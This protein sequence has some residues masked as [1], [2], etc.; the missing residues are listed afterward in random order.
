MAFRL[1]KQFMETKYGLSE[2]QRRIIATTDKAKGTLKTLADRK[3]YTT[4]TI[5]DDIGGRYSV[6]TSVGL[7]P[8]AVAGID[9]DAMMQ[10][11]QEASKAY[12]SPSIEKN[13][14]YAYAVS[15]R[16]LES[17]GKG[18]EL[19]VSYESQMAMFAE[20]WKQLF[21][22]SEGK[23]N[24]GLY[25]ASVNFSTDLH[26]MGQFV[27]EGTKS[28]FETLLHVDKPTLNAAFPSDGEDLDG[29]NYLAGK[30]LD[31]VNKNAALGTLQAHHDEGGIPVV[32]IHF[33]TM[34]AKNFGYLAQFFFIACGMSVYLLGV[35]PFNQPG[36]EVYKKNMFRLLG[37]K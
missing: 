36:V 31:E 21:G 32:Q 16:L 11:A 10:G 25:P 37:K 22:E 28:L 18:I 29:M 13:A 15:R 8:I 17:K 14:A 9:V 35:N 4:L 1:V 30:T 5:P 27:Q 2:A 6:L 24:K 33:E 12:Q 3:G 19:L 34:D 7:L 20:W 26:S 23:E